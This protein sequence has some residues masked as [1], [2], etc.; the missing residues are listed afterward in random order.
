MRTIPG[1]VDFDRVRRGELYIPNL[2]LATEEGLDAGIGPAH[3][4]EEP[5]L[6]MLTDALVD[7]GLPMGALFVP[8]AI[9][10][11]IRLARLIYLKPE[12]ISG[13]LVIREAHSARHISAPLAWQGT[14]GEPPPP[15]T[16]IR[17]E[18]VESGRWTARDYD[19]RG[20]FRK[21][22]RKLEQH[23][24]KPL[25]IWEEHGIESTIGA[26]VVPVLQEAIAWLCAARGIRAHVIDKG[27]I[28]DTEHYGAFLPCVPMP[29]LPGGGW[30]TRALDII[31]RT[32]SRILSAGWAKNYCMLEGH[33]QLTQYFRDV[34]DD[35]DFLRRIFL[36]D[37]CSSA[38]GEMSEED[39]RAYKA[40]ADAGLQTTTAEALISG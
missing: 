16:I 40:F 36:L 26:C 8:G 1:F 37:D 39:V 23:G 33:R 11:Q 7:F 22:P 12:T 21:Y 3:H 17:V 32:Y 29:W 28:D 4:D 5:T 15:R 24:Q 27:F 10:D 30:N 18:D 9:A 13:V 38:I 2:R 35:P 31:Y 20:W 6:L 19:R 14:S 25:V 34:F